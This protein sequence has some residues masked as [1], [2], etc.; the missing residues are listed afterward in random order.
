[1]AIE[2]IGLC[3]TTGPQSGKSF[4]A[5]EIGKMSGLDYT[6]LNFAGPVKRYSTLIAKSLLDVDLSTLDKQAWVPTGEDSGTTVRN[7]FRLIG[8]SGRTID[9]DLWV[10]LLRKEILSARQ[11]T[12]LIII[13]DLRYMNEF[14]FILEMGGIVFNVRD[15]DLGKA[16]IEDSGDLPGHQLFPRE[17]TLLNNKHTDL[18]QLQIK[19]K[20]LPLL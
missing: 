16:P 17:K 5:G 14:N 9:E 10:D 20:V 2:I 12:E 13:D 7:I 6:I 4:A 1:M 3:S 8:D 11:Y 19:E 18:L 15:T